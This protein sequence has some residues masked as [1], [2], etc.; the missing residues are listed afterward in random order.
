M[1]WIRGVP[2]R[3][4]RIRAVVTMTRALLPAMVERGS[5]L[6]I[7]IGSVA[8]AYPYPGGNVYC[9]SKAAVRMLT[10]CLK[11]DL[12]GSKVRVSTVELEAA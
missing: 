7:N 8:G 6:I 1:L 3:V 4:A 9:A 2:L 5:G 10:E 11:H 12:F